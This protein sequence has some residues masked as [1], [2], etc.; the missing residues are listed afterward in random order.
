MLHL[1]FHILNEINIE[2][3][4]SVGDIIFFLHSINEFSQN[5]PL[6][7]HFFFVEIVKHFDNWLV[8]LALYDEF[9]QFLAFQ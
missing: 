9:T 8:V 7:S 2:N 6:K 5:V 1:K 4:V 3:S